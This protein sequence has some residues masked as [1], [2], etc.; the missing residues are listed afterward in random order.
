V[1]KNH[2]ISFKIF[3]SHYSIIMRN[4]SEKPRKM[5]RGEEINIS[6]VEK[7]DES[8]YC[9]AR[10]E[11]EDEAIEPYEEDKDMQGKLMKKLEKLKTW[12]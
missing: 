5:G 7:E 8:E 12:K 4:H 10:L 9:S 6:N 1:Y 11:W 2:D 3:I